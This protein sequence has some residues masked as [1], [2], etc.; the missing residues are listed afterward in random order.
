MSW[1]IRW[2]N[3]SYNW[4]GGWEAGLSEATRYASEEEAFQALIEI[5]GV[6]SDGVVMSYEEAH[7]LWYGCTSE[8]RTPDQIKLGDIEAW[9]TQELKKAQL[10]WDRRPANYEPWHSEK[11][12]LLKRFKDK[13]F[14]T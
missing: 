1:V 10:E 3:G 7:V 6:D 11:E 5:N 13:F 12:A 9:I 2:N 4:E 14:P 8:Q